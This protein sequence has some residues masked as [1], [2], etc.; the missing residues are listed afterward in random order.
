MP[1]FHFYLVAGDERGHIRSIDLPS[2]S[3]AL[4]VGLE[5]TTEV[6]ALITQEHDLVEEG[7]VIEATDD[8]GVVVYTFYLSRCLDDHDGS[9]GYL[10]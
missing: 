10:H 5:L 1:Q 2:R 8:A 7:T 9:S 6:L 3:D 4:P